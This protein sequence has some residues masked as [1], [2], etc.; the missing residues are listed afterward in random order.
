MWGT[1]IVAL[2]KRTQFRASKLRVSAP[3]WFHCPGPDPDGGKLLRL[4]NVKLLAFAGIHRV[5][6]RESEIV[7]APRRDGICRDRRPLV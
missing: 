3:Q 2:G 5:G 6:Q 4:E 1:R 7:R